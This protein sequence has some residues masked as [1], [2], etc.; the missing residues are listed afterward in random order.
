[1]LPTI[2]RGDNDAGRRKEVGV[3]FRDTKAVLEVVSRL[4][5]ATA[6]AN[7]IML[8]MIELFV[9]ENETMIVVVVLVA[10]PWTAPK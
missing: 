2:V 6:V 5:S 1:M 4:R 8:E 9:E 10:V 3:F 7:F